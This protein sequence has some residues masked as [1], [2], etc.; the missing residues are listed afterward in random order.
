MSSPVFGVTADAGIEEAAALML[1]RGFT[2]LPVVTGEGR[3]LGV[4]T[5]ADLVGARFVP[6]ARGEPA[7]DSGTIPGLAPRRVRQLVHTVP[8]VPVTTELTDVI[9][10]MVDSGRRCVP[11]VADGNRLVG[12][13]SW[14]DVL[15]QLLPRT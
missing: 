9:A 3:L 8:P 12:M 6:G 1:E 15:A 11:V 14:R 4:V 7:P 13:I 5:E 2:T 10:I